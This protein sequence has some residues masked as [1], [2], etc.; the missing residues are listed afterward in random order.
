MARSHPA[1]APGGAGAAWPASA[2]RAGG[3]A[4]RAP[5]DRR[6]LVTSTPRPSCSASGST[7]ASTRPPTSAISTTG[8]LKL[9]AAWRNL[10]DDQ[11]AVWHHLIRREHRGYPEGWFTSDFATGLDQ[12]YRA[13]LDAGRMFVNDLYVTLVLHPGR[14]AADRAGAWLGRVRGRPAASASEDSGQ[15]AA[16]DA[17]RDLAQYL[18]RYGVRSALGIHDA[19]R[20]LV[21]RAAGA[22]AAAGIDRPAT[23]AVPLIRG[24]L[25]SAIYSARL[26][27]GREALEIRDAAD[28]RFAGVLGVKEYP[29][30]TRP[31]VWNGLLS[32]RFGF[33][34]SQSFAFLSK[35]AARAVM[36]RKQNQLLSS[37]D[38]AAS[39][40]AGLSDALDDL[41]SNRF[42]MGDHQASVPGLWR[43]RPA[44]WPTTS[45]KALL[46]A[47]SVP[48]SGLVT[49][50][51]DLALRGG[52]LG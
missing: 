50:R 16:L 46:C 33:I 42:A 14:D 39:Q 13:R 30:V 23:S 11:L 25:G 19:R 8:T 44:S 45:S 3:A 1:A 41:A 48:D 2:I 38:R 6:A 32:A 37:R 28:S 49:V 12:R 36:E 51:E 26:I 29:A 4:V 43:R 52:L 17:G 34:A 9:N 40:I 35:A 7:G 27:F 31:G 20:R 21:L 10:A 24:H 18:S 47:L 22:D 5:P 15:A